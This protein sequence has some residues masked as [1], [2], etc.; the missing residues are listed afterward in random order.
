F[1]PAGA[2]TAKWGSEGSDDGR[3]LYPKGI[4]VASPGKVFVA[5][6]LD[7]IQVFANEAEEDEAKIKCFIATAAYGSYLHPFVS[8][9]RAFRDSYLMTNRPGA[10]F[11]A[12]YYRLSPPLAEAIGSS[13]VLRAGVRILLLPF[14]GFGYLCLAIGLVPTLI[15]VLAALLLLIGICKAKPL[16]SGLRQ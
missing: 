6:A 1:T 10:S 14:V 8:I 12:W 13:P 16:I 15:L 2:F 11:V 9:L 5:D 3:F 7:R 4:A